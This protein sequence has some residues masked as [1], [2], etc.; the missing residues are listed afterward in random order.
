MT[1]YCRVI[2]ETYQIRPRECIY[3]RNFTNFIETFVV[4]RLGRVKVGVRVRVE[5]AVVVGKAAVAADDTI[6]VAIP[7]CVGDE[8]VDWLLATTSYGKLSILFATTPVFVGTLTSIFREHHAGKPWLNSS[9][10]ARDPSSRRRPF[11]QWSAVVGIAGC[12]PF[13]LF[14][15]CLLPAR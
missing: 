4:G 15:Q 13:R 1:Y 7:V 8:M 12:Q 11:G 14:G 2:Y 6:E 10:P 3:Q 9:I 5:S